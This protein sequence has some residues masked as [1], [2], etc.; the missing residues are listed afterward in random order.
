[1]RLSRSIVCVCV[2]SGVAY[3]KRREK[4]A[5]TE[6][7][8]VKYFSYSFQLSYCRLRAR[9]SDKWRKEPEK[10]EQNITS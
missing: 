3:G 1:M 10:R 9:L 2:C 8:S 6:N 5:G 4:M 7:T